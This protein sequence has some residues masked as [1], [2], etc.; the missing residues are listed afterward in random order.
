MK[1]ETE[2]NRMNENSAGRLAG[3]VAIVTGAA[4]GMGR[5]EA[6]LFASEGAT[7]FVADILDSAGQ[8]LAAT[9]RNIHYIHLDVAD[10]WQ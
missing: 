2:R 5:A 9:H 7:V 8:A 10:E 6:I 3:K 4:L 1:K